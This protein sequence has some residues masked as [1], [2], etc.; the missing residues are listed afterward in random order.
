MNWLNEI[1]A[2]IPLKDENIESLNIN[3]SEEYSEWELQRLGK[4]TSSRIGDLMSKGKGK[5]KFWGDM[6]MRY[7]YEKIAEL[8]TGIPHFNAESKSIQWGND[9]EHLAIEEYNK[10]AK[11][12]AKH[13]GTTFIKFN[14]MC[15]GSPDGFVGNDGIIEVKC[16]Y[17]SANHIKTF[18]TGEI[19]SDHIFQCQGNM[20][21]A[22]KKWC[23]YVSYDPRMPE[24]IQLK[25]IR[26]ERDYELCNQILDRITEAT[27]EMERIQ[28][29]TGIDIKIKF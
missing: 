10:G 16:P 25:I 27:K 3:Y 5:Y 20:L 12:K 14:D 8:M 24:G 2:N 19:S 6:A 7:I 13:M 11:V 1:G 26:V 29:L 22:D 18:I 4:F 9:N 28:K 23:D 21:F 15:G 17:V